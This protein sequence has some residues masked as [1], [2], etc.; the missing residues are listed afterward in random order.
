MIHDDNLRFNDFSKNN[1]EYN[2]VMEEEKQRSF[3]DLERMSFDDI[4]NF[5]KNE[6]SKGNV[7]NNNSFGSLNQNQEEKK[8]RLKIF[9]E[10]LKSINNSNIKQ[11]GYAGRKEGYR[12]GF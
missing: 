9:E 10:K 12:K 7:S 5:S 2:S 4:H 1:S 11:D 6:E 3:I 8:E